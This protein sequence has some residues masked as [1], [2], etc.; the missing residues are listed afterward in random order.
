MRDAFLGGLLLSLSLEQ[1]FV[2]PAAAEGLC[3]IIKWAVLGPA[4]MATALLFSADRK[5]LNIRSAQQIWINLELPQ[6]RRLALP[7]RER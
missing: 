3:E 2:D 5:T 7:K 6:K 1:E 4:V